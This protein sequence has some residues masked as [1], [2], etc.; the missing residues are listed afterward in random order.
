MAGKDGKLDS[1]RDESIRSSSF[2]TLYYNL[3]IHKSAAAAPE[4]F[5][6]ELEHET[7]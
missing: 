1:F 2:E 7:T 4:F 3:D 5:K 6:R